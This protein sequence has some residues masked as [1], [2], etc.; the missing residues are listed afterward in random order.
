MKTNKLTFVFD[1]KIFNRE[2]K[3]YSIRIGAKDENGRS[4]DDV[5]IY[6][7]TDTDDSVINMI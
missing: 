6:D 1:E 5:L 7:H 2:F 4:L 3:N